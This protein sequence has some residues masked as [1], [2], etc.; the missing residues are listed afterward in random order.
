MVRR[1]LVLAAFA[2]LLVAPAVA[3]DAIT[4]EG[5]IVCAKCT[6]QK[7]DATECQNVLVVSGKDGDQEYYLVANKV[8]EDFGHVCQGKKP[9]VVTGTVQEKDGKTWL[10][11]TEM[12]APAE[13][14]P[15]A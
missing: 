3:G 10:T 4:V 7:D 15:K 5:K 1:M 6:L 14:E 9:A 2:S 12:K 11:A 8:A 13:S